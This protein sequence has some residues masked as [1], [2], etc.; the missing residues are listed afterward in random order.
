MLAERV[1]G[2]KYLIY[3]MDVE[4]ANPE[5]NRQKVKEWIE[6]EVPRYQPDTIVL[7]EMWNT[8]YALDSLEEGADNDGKETLA[9]LQP[10]AKKYGIHII[11]GSVANRRK[12]GIY[13]S[14]MIIRKDGELI[15]EY[16]K[17]HLVPML[18][19]HK[20]LQ[21]GQAGG[22]IFELDG[23]KMG[24]VICYD[25]RFPELMRSIAIQGAE[26]IHVVAQ[27][28]ESRRTHWRYLQHGRAIENECYIISA[29]SS[30]SY[31]DTQFAGESLVI[32]PNGDLAAEGSPKKEETIVAT[33][34]LEKVKE[35]RERIPV[36]SDRVPNLYMMD[37]G[38]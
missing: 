3:Q 37:Q 25:L 30:G 17:M 10:L 8:G 31:D 18:D 12:D 29:N 35:M 23:I 11:G 24:L 7:P 1:K 9:L 20:F 14:S 27:W 28:P 26:V 36:F 16:D 6:K 2:L 38:Q 21:E 19:E 15:H 33:I 5:K 32:E 34:D 4:P 22:A 13:N